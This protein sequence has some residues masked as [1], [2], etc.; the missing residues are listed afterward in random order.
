M[1]EIKELN[2]K[3]DRKVLSNINLSFPR[4]GLIFVC[5]PSGCGKSTLLNCISGL[6]TFEGSVS[7]DG[8]NIENLNESELDSYRLD[9]IGFV[10]Q[11]FKVFENETVETN[12]SFPLDI[13]KNLS[14]FKKQQKVFDLIKLVGLEG[15]EKRLVT[16][17]S[18]GQKQR[19]GIARALVNDAKVILADEPTGALDEKCASDIMKILEIISKRKLVIIVSHDYELVSKYADEIIKLEDGCLVSHLYTNHEK[20]NDKLFMINNGFSFKKPSIP[21]YFIVK[22]TFQKVKKRPWRTIFCNLVTSFGLIGVG[23]ALTI[24]KTISTNIEDMCSSLMDSNRITVTQKEPSK[25]LITLEGGDF[26]DARF[27]KEK[28]EKY[29]SGVGFIY[30]NNFNNIFKDQNSFSVKGLFTDYH[31]SGYDAETINEFIWLDENNEVVYPKKPSTLNNDEI[32]IS[33]NMND[34]RSICYELQIYRTIESLSEYI[35]TTPLYIK[36]DVRTN[37]WE[38]DDTHLF[39]VKGFILNTN[40][41]IYHYNH[42]WNKEIFEDEM[43]LPVNDILYVENK[44]PWTL[45]RLPYLNCYNERDTFLDLFELDGDYDSYLLEIANSSYFPNTLE[46]DTPSKV[47][48]KLIFFRDTRNSINIRYSKLL[49]E[50]FPTLSGEIYGSAS[51]YAIFPSAFMMGFSNYFFLS[52]DFEMLDETVNIHSTLDYSKGEIFQV[53]DKI[54]VGHYSQS[55]NSGL[56]FSPVPNQFEG[57]KPTNYNEIVISSALADK[58]YGKNPIGQKVYC[59]YVSKESYYENQIIRDYSFDDLIICGIVDDEKFVVYHNPKWSINY[60]QYNLGVS[61]FNLGINAISFDD[62]S[63]SNNTIKKINEK[64]SKLYASSSYL[65]I[66]ESINEVCGYLEIAVSVF[67]IICIIISIVL[68]SM[69]NYLHISE[70]KVDIG[71]S[72]CIGINKK[73]SLKFLYFHSIFICLISFALSS[74][75]LMMCSVIFSKGFS[76]YF[77]SNPQ[78][79]FEPLALLAMF[80]LA[81]V[82]STLSSWIISFRVKKMSPLECLKP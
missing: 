82:I 65:E 75:E 58:L 17:L 73:E 49:K 11:D 10:F 25:T 80:I 12:I 50:D 22:H 43:R 44:Y 47:V 69:C 54:C 24:S 70:S 32:V 7:I 63:V 35:E 26:D 34:I 42:L 72:R 18:G 45:K 41:S 60:F 3:Y 51:G 36:F 16:N 33:L 40:K 48:N 14:D 23:L 8:L 53:N 27:C 71:L 21:A 56:T 79:V 9:T 38:Y 74:F 52:S 55:I 19:V 66:S 78:L 5:G 39:S 20:T 30:P 59:S 4:M 1:I 68:L 61:A 15:Y 2:K 67:S 57:N 31:L 6:V 29:I 37:E 81:I 76:S 28:Y 13:G 62:E 64:Y 46:I 77:G